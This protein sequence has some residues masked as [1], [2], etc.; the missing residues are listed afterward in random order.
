MF[1][2]TFNSWKGSAQERHATCTWGGFVEDPNRYENGKWY[3]IQ[4]G[5]GMRHEVPGDGKKHLPVGVW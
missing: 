1:C 5:G 2:S 3:Q 4:G